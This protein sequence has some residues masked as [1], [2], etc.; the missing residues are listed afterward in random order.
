MKAQGFTL[1]ELLAV[2]VIL[3][4]IALIATPIVLAIIEDIKE[5]AMLRSAEMY[6]DGVENAVMKENMNLGGNFKPTICEIEEGSISCDGKAP[7]LVE[8]DGEVPTSGN[9]I[10]EEGKIKEITLIYG[11]GTIV[12]D[13][14][15]N[16]VYQDGENNNQS[17]KI[18]TLANDSSVAA[19][20]S[21]A[22]YN[23]KVDPNKPEYIFYLLD[24][25]E[26][27]TS[28][29]I[30][31]ANINIAGEAVIPGVTSDTGSVV[32]YDEQNN[33]HGP[34]TAMTYLYNA[35]K[36]WS[37]VEP[38]NYTYNDRSVQGITGTDVG[39]Q[40]FISTNG[41]AVITKRDSS[42]TQVTIGSSTE[43]LRTRMPIYS[44]DTNVT[45]VTSMSNASYLYDNID[46]N[47]AY[48]GPYAYWTLSSH[49]DYYDFAWTVYYNG[50]VYSDGIVYSD[51]FPGV[52]PVI[53]VKL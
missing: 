9:I 19:G 26:D 49:A 36:S 38:L 18:C 45:E 48:S 14:S 28:D 29:L 30:M 6:L 2:I 52:R 40:S 39:Y 41:I 7:I 53:T 11:S 24:N 21:G 22:K 46:S 32:W 51:F 23:C 20:E 37:N 3:A 50:S 47:W 31:N 27:G 8:A 44:N 17:T 16:L 4:I 1:I 13:S 42:G 10:F 12:K 34:V 35:T 15:G 33:I 43:P 25:N 5:S